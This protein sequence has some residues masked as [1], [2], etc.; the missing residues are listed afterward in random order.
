[1]QYSNLLSCGVKIAKIAHD[2]CFACDTKLI[3]MATSLEESEELDW[4]EKIH[5]NTFHLAKKS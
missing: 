3:A 1:L 5:G 2:L 4:I